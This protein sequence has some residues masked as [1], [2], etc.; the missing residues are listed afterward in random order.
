MDLPLAEVVVALQTEL[1]R[2]QKAASDTGIRF[3][4]AGAQLEFHVALRKAA[5]VHTGV[6]F[7]VI[8]AGGKAELASEEIQKVSITLGPPSDESGNSVNLRRD[9]PAAP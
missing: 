5:D 8:E 3:P 9:W 2:A 6:K 7:W 1:L 4:V